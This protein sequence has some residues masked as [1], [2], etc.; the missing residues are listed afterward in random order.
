MA[1]GAAVATFFAVV[2]ALF[3]PWFQ[4]RFFPP[5]LKLNLLSQKGEGCPARFTKEWQNG[6]V[7]EVAEWTESGRFY[8]LRL[9]NMRRRSTAN[10]ALIYLSKFEEIG[11]DGVHSTVWTGDLPLRWRHSELFSK[12]R[13]VGPHADC[14]LCSVVS[15]SISAGR[16]PLHDP[17]PK[18][19]FSVYPQ[20]Q[21]NNLIDYYERS[22]PVNAV[23]TLQARS[24]EVDS[25]FIRVHITWDGAWVDGEGMKEHLHIKV[26][27]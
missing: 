9:V 10:E 11:A 2:A 20:T 27:P 26:L 3:N 8:H 19:R 13:T 24:N 15:G 22:A 14:D 16:T 18:P 5:V 7:L 21:V 4:A 17:A 1:L 12:A 23:L 25:E 6:P